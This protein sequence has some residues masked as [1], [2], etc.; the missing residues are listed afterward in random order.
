MVDVVA[1]HNLLVLCHP[2]HMYD[3][4]NYDDDNQ[5]DDHEVCQ[6]VDQIV[7]DIH[8]LPSWTHAR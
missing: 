2:G 5:D 1:A 4:G 6:D 8:A 7:F 3:D